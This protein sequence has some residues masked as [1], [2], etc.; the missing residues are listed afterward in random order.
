M[1]IKFRRRLML[2]PVILAVTALAAC[3]TAILSK[4]NPTETHAPSINILIPRDD[5]S[6]V[7]I[8]GSG[9]CPVMVEVSNFK[10]VD[11]PGEPNVAGEGHIHYFLDVDPPTEPGKPAVTAAGTYG[12]TADTVYWWTDIGK[13]PHT[14]S[15]ELVNNDHT[16]LNPPVIA[17]ARITAGIW[18]G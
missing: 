13:G 18:D 3:S 5:P 15:V 8:S 1:K 2:L 12:D 11:K 14:F 17:Q 4:T 6:A 16:P 10:L 9:N 7:G